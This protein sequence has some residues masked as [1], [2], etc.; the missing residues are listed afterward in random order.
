FTAISVKA[1][2]ESEH[3]VGRWAYDAGGRAISYRR[4]DGSE[5][6]LRFDEGQDGERMSTLTNAL[7]GRTTFRATEIAGRWR[8]TEI[9]GP[10]CAECG[11]T[12][13][14]MR[15]DGLGQLV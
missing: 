6:R 8:V 1:P 11:P 9:L 13:I 4:A 3:V 12:G 7:G 5:I 14:R 2:D 10:G 15:Y